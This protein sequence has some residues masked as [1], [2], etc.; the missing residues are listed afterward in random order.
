MFVAHCKRRAEGGAWWVGS[1]RTVVPPWLVE[2]SDCT[3]AGFWASGAVV[4]G[5][6]Q[7]R[8]EFT[9]LPQSRPT[10]ARRWPKPAAGNR[11]L[12]QATANDPFGSEPTHQSFLPHQHGAAV[13]TNIGHPGGQSRRIRGVRHL[14]AADDV[15]ERRDWAD[16]AGTSASMKRTSR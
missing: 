5:W 8:Y 10:R 7:A 3:A 13:A 14:R 16:A 2:P 6:S 9:A 4:A 1:T 15:R 12:D 11:W